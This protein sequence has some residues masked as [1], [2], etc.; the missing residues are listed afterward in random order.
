MPQAGFEPAPKRFLRPPPLPLGYCGPWHG[1]SRPCLLSFSALSRT[2]TC[3]N[4]TLNHAPLPNWAT[5]ANHIGSR[6]DS[7]PHLLGAN[8]G[9]CQIGR[10][11][12]LRLSPSPGTPGEG[13]G[14]GFISHLSVARRTRTFILG[15]RRAV[16]VLSSCRN[17]TRVPTTLVHQRRE[18]PAAKHL[19]IRQ[20]HQQPVRLRITFSGPDRIRTCNILVLSEA[21]RS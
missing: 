19:Q 14:E 3:T 21:P 6:R 4:V 1:L 5:R 13:R 17:V 9:S 12:R 2:R 18:S 20:R 15:L 8:Q 10:R 7:N 16:L 11:T